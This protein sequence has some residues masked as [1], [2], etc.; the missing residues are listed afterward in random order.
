MIRLG[1]HDSELGHWRAHWIAAQLHEQEVRSA[2]QAYSTEPALYEALLGK[3]VDALTW[4]A[5]ALP[6]EALAGTSLAALCERGDIRDALVAPGLGALDQLPAGTRV[7]AQGLLRQAQLHALRPD[8]EY[9][10]LLGDTEVQLTAL[11]QGEVSAVVVPYADLSRLGLAEAATEIL[12]PEL[13]L[14]PLAQGGTAVLCRTDDSTTL[15]LLQDSCDH[16]A[17]RRE[18]A[19]ELLFR[20]AWTQRYTEPVTACALA[21]DRFLYL[22]TLGQTLSGTL[23]RT[24][25]STHPSE[26]PRL[27]REAVTS[28]RGIIQ[29]T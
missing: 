6:L 11:D 27:V 20:Q 15:T 4:D 8:A 19:A 26:V 9:V 22:F 3:E 7:G 24:R 28:L 2:I 17:S 12:A 21:S 18:L 10:T 23:V 25:N 16:F 13:C 1:T 29:G 14:P 5:A